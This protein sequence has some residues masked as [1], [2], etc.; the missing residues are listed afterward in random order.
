MSCKDGKCDFRYS[1]QLFTDVKR[2]KK[3]SYLD[4]NVNE[5]D[6]RVAIK[7]IQDIIIERITGTCLADKLKELICKDEVYCKGNELYKTLLVDYLFNIFVYGVPLELNIPLSYKTR[8]AGQIRNND[9]SLTQSPLNDIKYTN[10]WYKFKMNFYIDR[11]MN[12]IRCNYSCIPEAQ[13]CSPCGCK[14]QSLQNP[15]FNNIS[16]YIPLK[17]R[18][19]Y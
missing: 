15:G 14:E 11:A 5:N 7:A 6:I 16:T 9:D 18:R 3:E 12:F 17:R 13:C 2:L 19:K 10:E 1:N 4:D 8:N